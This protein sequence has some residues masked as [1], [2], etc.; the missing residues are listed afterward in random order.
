[1]AIVKPALMDFSDKRFS[2]II[3]GSP[4]IGK[5]TLALSAPNP[6]LVDFDG[7]VSR[8]RAQH[9]KDTIVAA[10]YEEVL[11][12]VEGLDI[13]EYDTVII[14]TG[15]SFVTYLQE[16]AKRQSPSNRR[17]DGGISQ[18]GF[19]A[20]K[21]EFV[22]FTNR[23]KY[24]LG[25]NVIYI[26][27]TVEE[28]NKDGD[29]VQRLMCEGSAKNIVWQPCDFG[30]FLDVSGGSRTAGFSP[31]EQHFAK[32]CHGITGQIAVPTLGADTPNTF[33]TELFERAKANIAAESTAFEEEKAAY[34]ATMEKGA[35]TIAS[36]VDCA[37]AETA[38]A[39]ISGTPNALTSKR[40]LRAA[41]KARLKEVGVQ[42]SKE[43]GAYVTVE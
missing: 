7:G 13:R 2:M 20:V 33:L 23:L 36:I 1:M 39:E 5:T 17:K 3:C 42:W 35:A 16:W 30:C 11:K 6:V 29:I 31:T 37:T 8:V 26:F 40:E 15:G 9:R 10:T 43:A 4:G 19:G 41:L 14:D 24:A 22:Q 28:K 25:K 12:D 38:S 18:Q 27:H 21:Q 34:Q 32:G